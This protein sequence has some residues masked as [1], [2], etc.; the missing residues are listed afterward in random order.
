MVGIEPTHCALTLTWTLP[1]LA[2]SDS[3]WWRQVVRHTIVYEDLDGLFGAALRSSGVV[4]FLFTSG[5]IAFHR[6]VRFCLV[7]TL[8]FRS[9]STV[10]T[11]FY[12]SKPR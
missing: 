10:P 8:S 12:A 3:C 9:C 1:R 5:L 11:A 6:W 4:A 2:Y 7:T